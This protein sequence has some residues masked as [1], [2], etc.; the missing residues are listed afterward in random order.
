MTL[1]YMYHRQ[2]APWWHLSTCNITRRHI[3]DI[4]VHSLLLGGSSVALE[5]MYVLKEELQ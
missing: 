2:E 4:Q 1:E 5:Y 3:T